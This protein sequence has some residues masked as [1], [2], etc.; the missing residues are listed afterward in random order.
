[1]DKKAK[2]EAKRVRRTKKKRLMGATHVTEE[3]QK[4]DPA[5]RILNETGLSG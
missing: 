5:S 1:M 4:P 3:P 2:A